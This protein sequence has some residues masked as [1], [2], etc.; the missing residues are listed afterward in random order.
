[1]KK[2]G[3]KVTRYLVGGKI[4]KSVYLVLLDPGEQ[5][6]YSE[7]YRRNSRVGSEDCAAGDGLGP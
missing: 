5:I 7:S 6:A 4:L 3:K 1:M 2:E